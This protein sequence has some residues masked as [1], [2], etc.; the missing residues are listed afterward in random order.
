[1]DS[2]KGGEFLH[3]MSDYQPVIKNF[4]HDVSW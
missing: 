2:I 3:Q 1:M 4:L